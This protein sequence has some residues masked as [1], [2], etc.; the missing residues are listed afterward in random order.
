MNRVARI[1]L[2]L[3]D[4]MLTLGCFNGEVTQ[5]LRITRRGRGSSQLSPPVCQVDELMDAGQ[6]LLP[7]LHYVIFA[8]IGLVD[9]GSLRTAFIQ[10]AYP[11]WNGD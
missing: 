4:L 3:Y 8:P 9:R 2:H 11:A 6:L 10:G 1:H 7:L 5:I